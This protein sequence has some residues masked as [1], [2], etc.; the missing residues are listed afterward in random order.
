MTNF[1]C[2]NCKFRKER[3][4]GH[5]IFLSCSDKE[6]AKGYKQSTWDYSNKCIN[7]EKE[8]LK[9]NG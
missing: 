9:K 3:K 6:K 4:S 8:E 5:R 7:F 1:I 2:S